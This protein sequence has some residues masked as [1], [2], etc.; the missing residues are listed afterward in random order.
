[1]DIPGFELQQR[2]KIALL[3]NI[4]TSSNTHLPYLPMYSG[5]LP[6]MKLPGG[7]TDLSPPSIAE[8]EN[9]WSFISILSKRAQ[10]QI[11]LQ[12]K[13]L[14]DRSALFGDKSLA[15]VGSRTRFLC[16]PACVLV[17]I[18]TEP[19]QIPPVNLSRTKIVSRVAW[20]Q[21]DLSVISRCYLQVHTVRSSPI[22]NYSTGHV[23]DTKQ[24]T[25]R[26]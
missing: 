12:I 6:G 1:M 24:V 26:P 22:L 8:A 17:I 10:G 7:K 4:T 11:Y 14:S 9:E 2:Q 5:D 13:H 23:T 16:P 18:P 20:V 15:S 25:E 21:S 3:Q 19:S